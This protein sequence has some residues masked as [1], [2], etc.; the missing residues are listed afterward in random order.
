MSQLRLVIAAKRRSEESKQFPTQQI[1]V[2][3]VTIG[4]GTYTNRT[5]KNGYQLN[6]SYYYQ[7]ITTQ[8]PP[9][10]YKNS[11]GYTQFLLIKNTSIKND[12]LTSSFI[13]NTTSHDFSYLKNG[14]I[15]RGSRII[16]KSMFPCT[17]M[18]IF[19]NLC[20]LF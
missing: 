10:S 13:K 3:Y 5:V 20:A 1:F 9:F 16:N 4:S 8:Q 7:K 14:N 19:L 17:F 18:L 6:N 11:S 2:V 12:Q 15:I